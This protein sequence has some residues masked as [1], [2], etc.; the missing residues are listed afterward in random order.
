MP[1]T[2]QLLTLLTAFATAI[3][4]GVF[5]AFSNF[6]M[7]ALARSPEPEATRAMQHINITVLNPGFFA[8]FFGAPLL[9]LGL[10]A[11]AWLTRPTDHLPLITAACL[12]HTLGC[13]LA[14]IAFN[15]PLNERLAK[16]D[17]DA[18]ETLTHWRHYLTTWTRWNHLRTTAS[19]LATLLLTY[20]LI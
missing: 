18:P 4:A 3:N 13:F 2:L 20:T 14:T 19:A 12:L 10:L 8:F 16:R 7:A 9:C 17:A 1:N 15:V 11:T 5:F 6:I